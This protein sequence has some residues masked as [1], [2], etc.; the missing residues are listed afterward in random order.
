MKHPLRS[1][2]ELAEDRRVE[3][4]GPADVEVV[5]LQGETV[6]DTTVPRSDGKHAFTVPAGTGPVFVRARKVVGDEPRNVNWGVKVKRR[7]G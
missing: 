3:T 5:D 6:L 1:A 4:S 7:K 2:R